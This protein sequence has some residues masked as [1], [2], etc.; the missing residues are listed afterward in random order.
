MY[1]LAENQLMYYRLIMKRGEP[2]GRPGC[3]LDS[4]SG[5]GGGPHN[6]PSTLYRGECK[7]CEAQGVT[8]E[9]AG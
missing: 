4:K 6:V 8:G 7:L 2:C 9:G 3:V 1:T 5:G